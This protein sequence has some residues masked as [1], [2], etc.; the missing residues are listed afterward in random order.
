MQ[1]VVLVARE[2]VV[3]QSSVIIAKRFGRIRRFKFKHLNHSNQEERPEKACLAISCY[4]IL[5]E[6]VYRI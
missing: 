5:Y 3:S 4:V 2:K 1:G 6:I